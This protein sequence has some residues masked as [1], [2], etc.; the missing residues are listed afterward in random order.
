M[1]TPYVATAWFLSARAAAPPGSGL[2]PLTLPFPVPPPPCRPSP[3]S[4]SR[5]C[6]LSA[7]VPAGPQPRGEED[8]LLT[9]EGSVLSV[10]IPPAW[11]FVT[12]V[13]LAAAAS[14]ASLPQP[15]SCPQG[16]ALLPG[17]PVHLS[18]GLTLCSSHVNPCHGDLST[19]HQAGQLLPV[20]SWSPQAATCLTPLLG[21][22]AHLTS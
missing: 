5:C 3:S 8:P 22:Q 14:G 17:G 20:C 18:F 21:L 1:V 2:H 16:L 4:H 11:A 10:P 19:V 9:P 7:I 15:R 13:H 6:A 12:E